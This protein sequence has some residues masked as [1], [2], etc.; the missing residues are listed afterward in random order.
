MTCKKKWRNR[1]ARLLVGGAAACVL[2]TAPLDKAAAAPTLVTAPDGTFQGKLDPTVGVR[3]FLGLRYAQPPTGEQ[4][5][6]SPRP[7]VPASGTQDATHH[8]NHCPQLG[9]PT[10]FESFGNPSVTEDCLF[11]NVF[12]SDDDRD[13]Q[14]PVMV[15]IHPSGHYVGESDEYDATKLVRQGRVVVVTINYRLG[16]LG[17]LA[18]P[19][20]TAE[21]PDH[22]SGNYG[23]EDQQAALKWVQ[24]NIAAFGGN[25]DRVTIF[26]ADVLTNLV[27]PTAKGL[28]HRAIVE[29]DAYPVTKLPTLAEAEA[30]GVTFATSVG[31]SLPTA[32][33]VLSCLRALSVSQLLKLFPFFSKVDGKIVTQQIAAALATGQFNQVPLMNGS[34]HDENRFFVAFFDLLGRGPVTAATYPTAIFQTIFNA[35]AVQAVEAQYPLTS[36]DSPDLAVGALGTDAIWACPAHFLDELASR[37]VPTYAYE[38]ND[39]NA[40][41]NYNPPVSFP[42][43]ATFATQIQYLFPPANPTGLGLNLSPTPLNAA[44]QKLSDQ[45]VSYWTEFAKSGNPNS[46]ATP[47]WLRF[48]GR[49]D[50]IQ[51]L[52]TPEPHPEFDFATVHKCAFWDQLSGRTLPPDDGR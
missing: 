35:S 36:F 22:T 52:N 9:F 3:E 14:R 12:A 23:I 26:G 39:E 27:S 8:A 42:Y 32:T 51:S 48:R 46:D 29:S 43:G 15:L 4:R 17:F 28:F 31:C 6:K 18:H 34:N 45:M 49:R 11:L 16:H 40:P 2:A 41:E 1:I 38:F 20:L 19:A 37:F 50:N 7:V 13:N 24:R 10:F 30:A 44:Q 33:Q 5:W 21:S 47:S 25:P